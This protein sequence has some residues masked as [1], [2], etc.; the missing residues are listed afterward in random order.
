M[1]GDASGRLLSW[2]YGAG[3]K[4]QA[5]AVKLPAKVNCLAPLP[6]GACVLA[7][8]ANGTAACVDLVRGQ[9]LCTWQ[10]HGGGVTALEWAPAP[11]LP[12]PAAGLQQRQQQQP[13]RGFILTGGDSA[14]PRV[15]LWE[16][17]WPAD[18]LQPPAAAA[19]SAASAAASDSGSAADG[20]PPAPSP[21]PSE[22]AASASPGGAA[23]RS[24]LLPAPLPLVFVRLPA[25]AASR[26]G[27]QGEGGAAG[28]PPA[29]WVAASL[30]PGSLQLD[31]SCWVV[32]GSMQGQLLLQQLVPGEP[33]LRQAMAGLSR[34]ALLRP[35][36][37]GPCFTPRAAPTGSP[38]CLPPPLPLQV[39]SP[40]PTSAWPPPTTASSSR[41]RCCSPQQR[42]TPQPP[43][44]PLAPARHVPP[45][46]LTH[47]PPRTA[48]LW[49]V[50]RQH[51][52]PWNLPA[53][54]PAA[55]RPG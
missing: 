51:A 36:L 29:S 42:A 38:S 32:A 5:L 13:G 22:L 18:A 47:P 54:R 46:P 3:T 12:E 25:P 30:V 35:G 31:G 34:V 7:G 1:Y 10:A 4:M 52:A 50:I 24:V 37:P 41:W 26:G 20:D 39:P 55:P 9:L 11:A 33:R 15:Q 49:R 14:G 53:R 17:F 48:L 44:P 19:I 27:S 40:S 28:R 23:E 8:C 6:G 16:A 2:G 43:P 21:R 45:R